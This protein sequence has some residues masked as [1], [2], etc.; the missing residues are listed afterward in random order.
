MSRQD[1]IRQGLAAV[2]RRIEAACEAAGRA[3]DE[4]TLVVVTKFF[5]P[6]DIEILHDLGI[7]DIGENKDQEASAKLSDLACRD[8][9]T[10]HFVGQLQSNKATS[11]CRYADVIHSVDRPRLV[12]ALDRALQVGHRGSGEVT[13]LVQVSLDGGAGRGGVAPEDAVALADAVA[14]TALRLG[15]VMA[16]APLG[17]EPG[18][19][20]AR[21][22]EVSE[23]VREAHPGA[24]WVSAGMS[25]DLEEAVAHGATH[26]RVGRAILGSR[27]SLG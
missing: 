8:D 3:R 25:D 17:A 2:D 27:P 5:P 1:E 9:L 20:F 12:R 11:V 24:T 4:V 18:A 22:R 14:E 13:A 19:A 16:V 15:G 26:L 21:L 7:R 10:V 23:A 6:T